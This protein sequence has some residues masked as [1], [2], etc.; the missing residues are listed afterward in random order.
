[1]ILNLVVVILRHFINFLLHGRIPMVLDSI[2]R[3]PFEELGNLRPFVA[4]DP[5][6]EIKNPFLVLTPGD[7]FDLRVEMIVPSFTALLPD[8]AR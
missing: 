8:S 1:V 2:V 4:H 3:A 7:F 5:V 6:L